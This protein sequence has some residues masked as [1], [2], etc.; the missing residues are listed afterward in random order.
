MVLDSLVKLHSGGLSKY[1]GNW[2]NT[3]IKILVLFGNSHYNLQSFSW[4]LTCR[5]L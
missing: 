2:L 5:N 4:I 1:G 3:F